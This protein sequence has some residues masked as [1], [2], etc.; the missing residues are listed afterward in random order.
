M[1]L[2][3][4]EDLGIPQRIAKGYAMIRIIFIF[5]FFV[6]SLPLQAFEVSPTERAFRFQVVGDDGKPVDGIPIRWISEIEDGQNAFGGRFYNEVA[7]KVILS[8]KGGIVEIPSHKFGT[9]S[10]SIVT[11]DLMKS[12][13]WMVDSKTSSQSFRWDVYDID[14][15]QTHVFGPPTPG[16]DAVFKVLSKKGISNLIRYNVGYKQVPCDGTPTPLRVLGGPSAQ[17]KNPADA[18]VVITIKRPDQE[19]FSKESGLLGVAKPLRVPWVLESKTLR[20]AHL[21]SNTDLSADYRHRTWADRLEVEPTHPDHAMSQGAQKLR[22]WALIPGDRPLVVPLTCYISLSYD[23][24]KIG[25][26][27]YSVR[28]EVILPLAPCTRYHPDL[29]SLGGLAPEISGDAINVRLDPIRVAALAHPFPADLTT[30]SVL[31][32]DTNPK[33]PW[34]WRTL[35]VLLPPDKP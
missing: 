27:V 6:L 5:F 30:T 10:V 13:D 15:P 28:F 3:V 12:T 18:D 7:R 22:L 2:L 32:Y 25:K 1:E 31:R 26:A 9:F 19:S 24:E 8:A 23:S 33:L 4:G 20:F 16:F 14:N 21:A 29:W 17:V 34:D 35:P 11:E